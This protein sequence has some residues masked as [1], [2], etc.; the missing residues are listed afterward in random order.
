MIKINSYGRL[1]NKLHHFVFAKYISQITNQTLIPERIEGFTQTYF[2]HIGTDDKDYNYVDTS[3]YFRIAEDGVFED[4][5]KHDGG[6]IV[7]D[8][9]TQYINFKYIVPYIKDYLQIENEDI[10]SKPNKNDLV[11]HIRL[12]D[13][14]QIGW[15]TEKYLFLKVIEMEDYDK[16]YI[17][18]DEP[19]NPWLKEFKDIGCIIKSG[20]LIQDFSFIKNANKICISKSTFSWMAAIASDAEKVYFPLS[21]NKPPY[22]YNPNIVDFDF[23]LRPLDKKNWIII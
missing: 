21:D 9:L 13:Y 3:P 2:N 19:N 18:T 11:I 4:I 14:L 17:I 23:D 5:K 12:G 16:C 8:M 1:G 15:Y 20:S 7:N 6:I 22:L 10:L